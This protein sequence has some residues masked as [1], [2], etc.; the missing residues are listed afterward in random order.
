MSPKS[1]SASMVTLGY[2][3]HFLEGMRNYWHMLR[4][5]PQELDAS[6]C[7]E[8]SFSFLAHSFTAHFSKGE[9]M[10]HS[11]SANEWTEVNLNVVQASSSSLSLSLSFSPFVSQLFSF[12]LS[13]SLSACLCGVKSTCLLSFTPSDDLYFCRAYVFVLHHHH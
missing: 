7:S 10:S 6:L 8:P 4:Q 1:P 2:H 3:W 5:L 9:S 13:L 12:T 11:D